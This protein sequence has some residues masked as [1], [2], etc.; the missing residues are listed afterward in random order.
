[1]S[2]VYVEDFPSLYFL[3]LMRHISN[4]WKLHLILQTWFY[5]D[6][7]NKQWFFGEKQDTEDVISHLFP[8][9]SGKLFKDSRTI[10]K[11]TDWVCISVHFFFHSTACK[12]ETCAGQLQLNSTNLCPCLIKNGHPYRLPVFCFARRKKVKS[13]WRCYRH[14]ASNSLHPV[15]WVLQ[16]WNLVKVLFSQE[17]YPPEV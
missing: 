11:I 4:I 13:R 17:K 1:M 10:C 15:I 2:T 7:S 3:S 8:H 16:L 9:L 6:F 12:S 5:V 14:G